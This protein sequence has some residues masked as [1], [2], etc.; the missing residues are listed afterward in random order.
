MANV[1]ITGGAGYVGAVVTGAF[2][3]AGHTVTVLDRLD[4][5]GQG[6]LGYVP[7]TRFRFLAGDVRDERVVAEAVRGQDVLLHLAAIVGFGECNADP[8]HAESV[9]VGGTQTLLAARDPGQLVLYASTGSVYGAVPAGL[10][11]EGLEPTPLSQYGSTKLAA[12]RLIVE[13]G[14]AVAFRF[15]TAFGMSPSMRI[16]LLVNGFVYSAKRRGYLVVYDKDARRT[17][18]HVRDMARAFLFALDN[19]AAMGGQVYNAG[20]E[21]LNH[22][23]DEIARLI[24]ARHRYFLTYGPVGVDEDQ[25]DYAVSYRKLGALGFTTE[26]SLEEGIDELLRGMDLLHYRAPYGDA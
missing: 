10:C 19:C 13:S 21:A 22:T 12:E 3:D 25:R 24:L 14:N 9:N 18:I 20:S 8:R 1:L 17:F 23:K 7:Q 6:L 11:H 26:I 15:A 2:L 16:D 4:D 5:D